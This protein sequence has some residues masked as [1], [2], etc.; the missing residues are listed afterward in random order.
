MQTM[1]AKDLNAMVGQTLVSPGGEKIGKI[2]DVY[3]DQRS[4]QPE[5]LAVSTGMFG[6]KVSFV[7][8]TGVRRAGD[9]YQA[10]FD[11]EKV[12]EAPN[13]ERD[14]ALSEAEEDRLYRHY[15]VPAPSFSQATGQ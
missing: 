4:D 3:V 9:E 11:K 10:S 2:A 13:A 5:W 14:G 15:G 1:T 7:P 6:S 8:L 12:K